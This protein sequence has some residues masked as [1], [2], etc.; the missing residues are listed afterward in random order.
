[1]QQAVAG[2]L[3]ALS[4]SCLTPQTGAHGVVGASGGGRNG[5]GEA[6]G[7]AVESRGVVLADNVLPYVAPT[8]DDSGSLFH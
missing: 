4:C 2:L 1:V 7:Y 6:G 8:R 5:I 3:S